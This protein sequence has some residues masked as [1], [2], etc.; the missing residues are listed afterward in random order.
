MVYFLKNSINQSVVKKKFQAYLEIKKQYSNPKSGIFYDQQE[1]ED[2]RQQLNKG[3]CSGFA[4]LY[5][6]F[7]HLDKLDWWFDLLDR[8]CDWDGESESLNKKV[9]LIN[10]TEAKTLG[11][12]FEIAINY[13]RQTQAIEKFIR[14]YS[15]PKNPDGQPYKQ[16]D[17]L[18]AQF[19][20]LEILESDDKLTRLKESQSFV[21]HGGSQV[22]INEYLFCQIIEDAKYSDIIYLGLSG[23]EVGHGCSVRFLE[24]NFYLYDSNYPDGDEIYTNLGKMYR[25]LKERYPNFKF[26]DIQLAMFPG[27]RDL[28][29]INHCYRNTLNFLVESSQNKIEAASKCL[30]EKLYINACDGHGNTALHYAVM[31]NNQQMATMLLDKGMDINARGDGK[32]SALHEAVQWGRIE[33]ASFLLEKKADINLLAGEDGTPLH[34]AIINENI[35]MVQLLLTQGADINAPNNERLTPLKFARLNNCPEEIVKLL[36]DHGASVEPNSSN[37]LFLKMKDFASSCYEA[38]TYGSG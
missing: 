17:L 27:E 9:Q 34:T 10:Q 5:S 18:N 11:E 3:H 25:T 33:M 4:V 32:A 22:G 12:L 35:E 2:I 8:L 7:S 38:F 23:P 15:D 30:E 19:A 20:L 21:F 6:V 1:V 29:L 36:L 14:N 16:S 24:G 13:V 26:S 31:H 37:Y 28:S